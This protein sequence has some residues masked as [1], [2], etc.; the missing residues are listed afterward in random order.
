[1][2]RIA[3][4]EKWIRP[5][6]DR[7]EIEP[8]CA[9]DHQLPTPKDRF[10]WANMEHAL[11]KE[12]EGKLENPHDCHSGGRTIATTGPGI[13]LLPVVLNSRGDIGLTSDPRN[14]SKFE[15]EAHFCDLSKNREGVIT[16]PF[17]HQNL[18]CKIGS[19][20]MLHAIANLQVFV[21][22]PAR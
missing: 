17:Q 16:G 3:V 7:S 9:T 6:L 13:R 19:A 5:R 12:G 22:T 20:R 18:I 4:F 2:R 21:N 14:T 11:H 10:V 15:S 1:M 8:F